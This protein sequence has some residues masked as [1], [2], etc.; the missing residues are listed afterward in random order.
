MVKNFPKRQ[1]ISYGI[2]IL[3]IAF[4][5]S[6][7]MLKDSLI[8][9]ASK[10]MQHQLTPISQKI[11]ADSIDHLYNYEKAGLHF[12][13]TLLEFSGA[14]CSICRKMQTELDALGQT[15][16]Q[17]VNIVIRQMT[18]PNGLQWGKYFGVVM[19]PTQIILD[20]T[21]KEIFRNTGFIS[22]EDLLDRINQ[23]KSS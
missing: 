14:G 4:V 7:F 13:Y 21:G 16:G 12:Q 17:V 18:N 2:I 22:K 6:L 5:V 15:H 20:N 19:I 8:T 23:S 10:G 1:L 11:F 9:Y 3:M